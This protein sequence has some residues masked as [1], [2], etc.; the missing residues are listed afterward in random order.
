VAA[1]GQRPPADSTPTLGLES[2]FLDFRTPELSLRLVRAS[3]TVAALGPVDE[4]DFDFTPGDWLERRA[5]NDYVHLGDLTLRVRH[6]GSEEWRSYSTAESR[7]AVRA[8]DVASSQPD[9]VLAAAD[10]APTLPDDIP[11]T[12]VRSWVVEGGT[13]SVWRRV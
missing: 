2:G 6:P 1:D 12:V 3:Q 5:P 13:L 8:L 10:L 7:A 9:G 11:L 4:P